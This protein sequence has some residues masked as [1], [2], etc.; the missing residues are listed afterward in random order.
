VN[1][2]YSGA[3]AG[4]P[5]KLPGTQE[6]PVGSASERRTARPL[7]ALSPRAW[8]GSLFVCLGLAAFAATQGRLGIVYGISQAAMPWSFYF[9]IE[10]PLWLSWW[11]LIPVVGAV[12]QRWPVTGALSTRLRLA[13]LGGHLLA[14]LASGWLCLVLAMMGQ[15][16]LGLRGHP[17]L[18]LWQAT[19]LAYLYRF[20]QQLLIYAAIAGVFG[21]IQLQREARR[22]ALGE[23]ILRGNLLEARLEGLE[24][25]LQPHFLFNTLNAISGLMGRDVPAARSALAQLSDLLRGVLDDDGGRVIRLED[26][27]TILM[28]YVDLLRLRFGDRLRLEIDIPEALHTLAVPRLLLQPLVEN[29]VVHGLERHR[30]GGR[31]H[32]SARQE[33]AGERL[34]LRV[35]DDGVGPATGTVREGLGLGTTRAR[36]EALYGDQAGIRLTSGEDGGAVVEV[37]L[38]AEAVA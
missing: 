38:P 11:L 9:V 2:T 20:D 14:G 34:V 27:L 26:E 8:A 24:A 23:S 22:R 30:E 6:Q 18:S 5:A 7:M 4:I 37:W 31:I 12:S 16:L 3:V 35:E 33:A 29:A 10:L 21:V 1:T 15:D 19:N 13:H 28:R 17:D 36:L 25:R 32:L